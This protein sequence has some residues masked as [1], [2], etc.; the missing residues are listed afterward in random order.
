MFDTDSH[1]PIEQIDDDRCEHPGCKATA[2]YERNDRRYCRSH[3][4]PPTPIPIEAPLFP[5][6]K[7]K[8]PKVKAA[9]KPKPPPKPKAP[10]PPKVPKEK[11]PRVRAHN[12]RPNCVVPGCSNVERRAHLCAG[13]DGACAKR[14]L[15]VLLD[16]PLDVITFT[17]AQPAPVTY[18]P[19]RDRERPEACRA[20]GCGRVV[21]PNRG[22]LCNAH[23]R[24]LHKMGM[25]IT[26]STPTATIDRALAG[27]PPIL[28]RQ[29]WTHCRRVGCGKLLAE[30]KRQ[31]GGCCYQC[32]NALAAAGFRVGFYTTDAE[33]AEWWAI[34]AANA[35]RK[36]RVV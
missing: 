3:F 4:A 18:I 19:K 30:S 21:T 9:P 24:R 35:R 12:P 14:G 5:K 6:A 26:L 27:A 25:S 31:C 22:G 8:A 13:H 17:L 28:E 36:L 33:L 11:K 16:T 1:E 2:F 15:H 23:Y 32:T 29:H 10:K 7:P 20:A 34:R